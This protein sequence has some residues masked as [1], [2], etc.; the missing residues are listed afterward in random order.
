MI[1]AEVIEL[2]SRVPVDSALTARD[3]LQSSSTAAFWSGCPSTA[4]YPR[5]RSSSPMSPTTGGSQPTSRRTVSGLPALE[6]LRLPGR[7]P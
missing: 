1:D 5:S 2:R 3:L 7:G 4:C 6:A